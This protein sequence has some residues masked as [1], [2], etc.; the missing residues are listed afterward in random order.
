MEATISGFLQAVIP[1]KDRHHA[2]LNFKDPFT[3][4]LEKAMVW[5]CSDECRWKF[6]DRLT[7]MNKG[8]RGSL[9]EK[10]CALL[11]NKRGKCGECG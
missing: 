4:A 9:V 8:E 11:L 1:K 6:S 7:D 2:I 10:S 5:F 3:F